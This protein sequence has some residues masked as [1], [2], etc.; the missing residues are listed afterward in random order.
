MVIASQLVLVFVWIGAATSKFTHHFSYVIQVMVS[1]TPW[2]RSRKAKANLYR[3]H[4]NSLLPSRQAQFAAHFGTFLE[5]TFPIL[6]LLGDGGLLTTIAVA[7]ALIFHIHITSTLPLG[8]PLEWNLFMMFGIVWLF[9]EYAS[10]PFS[11]LDS[12]PLLAIVL[13][14]GLVVPT[15]GRL[16]PQSFSFLWAMLY[17]AGNWATSLWLFRRDG[18]IEDRVDDG[19]T[20]SAKFAETQLNKLYDADTA[21]VLLYKGLAFRAM[22]SHGRA[23]NGLLPRLV[24]D[25]EGYKVRDGEIVAGALAGWNFGDGHFHHE[26]LLEAVQER[27][28]LKEGDIRVVALESQP[29]YMFRDSKQRYRL[30]DA[31]TGLIEEGWVRCGEMT[32]REPWLDAPGTIPVEVL[33]TAR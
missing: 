2:N 8:V 9:A 4:P 16:R 27:M 13:F 5:L 18:D 32:S 14:C 24:D 6:L 21:E 12:L 23:L 10:V 17:Y 33:H 11:T 30:L 28:D 26:Q 3:D 1:N 29:T 20:K 31:K 7:V 25:V 22:H 19:I 15:L